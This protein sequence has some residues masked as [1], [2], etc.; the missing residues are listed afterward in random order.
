MAKTIDLQAAVKA[1][2]ARHG[3]TRIAARALGVN[4]AYLSRLSTGQKSNPTDATLRKLGL[5][6]VVTYTPI[7]PMRTVLE[8]KGETLEMKS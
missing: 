6:K 8:F 4:Y 2:I 3:G 5:K 7:R 1:L